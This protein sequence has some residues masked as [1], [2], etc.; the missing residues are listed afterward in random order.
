MA[1]IAGWLGGLVQPAPAASAQLQF[2]YDQAGRLV[3][4]SAVDQGAASYAYDASGNLLHR[5]FSTLADADGDGLV[6]ALE[7]ALGLDPADADSDD[8]G[9]SDGVE[10]IAGTNP[11]NP[12]SRFAVAALAMT[13]AGAV[14]IT[15][16]S[17]A[18]RRYTLQASITLGAWEDVPG[19]VAVAGTGA[20]LVL[21]DSEPDA[22]S[23]FYRVVVSW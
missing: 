5:S 21:H 20:A 1:L 16:S 18:G 22:G 7:I 15:V 9:T 2:I 13:P 8:D 3:A 6:T 23:I 4:V 14:D 12:L 19:A 17:V 11:M 10:V